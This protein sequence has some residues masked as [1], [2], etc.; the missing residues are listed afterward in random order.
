MNLNKFS[1]ANMQ[2]TR[3]KEST[4]R[5]ARQGAN[6]I[7]EEA[8]AALGITAGAKIS[9]VQDND[10]PEDWFV[11]MDEQE[12]FVLRAE[13]KSKRLAFNCAA[14]SNTMLDALG[15]DN[16]HS[17][18]FKLVTEAQEIEGG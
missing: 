14:L 16:A 4:L 1:A 12:G 5:V 8:V 18:T 15:W 13:S 3:V 11:I 9:L 7:S 10:H 17:A 2:H 6:V